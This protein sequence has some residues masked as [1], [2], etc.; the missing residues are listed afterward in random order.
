MVGECLVNFH[1]SSKTV[2]QPGENAPSIAW[3]WWKGWNFG[4]ALHQEGFCPRECLG[5]SSL[6]SLLPFLCTAILSLPWCFVFN[7]L[8]SSSEG[9]AVPAR[10]LC[11]SLVPLW[12][13]RGGVHHLAL[14]V[15]SLEIFLPV[16]IPISGC[17]AGAGSPRYCPL[18]V[19]VR[20]E[21]GWWGFQPI[22][23][24]P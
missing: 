1:L 14:L 11:S 21:S 17:V 5:Q 18:V 20:L 22:L 2:R 4:V 15:L 8:S 9:P 6:R 23:L 24:L 19:S 7:Q 3:K 10:A 13:I 16:R 12:A